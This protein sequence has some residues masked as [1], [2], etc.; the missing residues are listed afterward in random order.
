MRL[1]FDQNLSFRLS[2]RL[3]DLYPGLSQVRLLG[4]DR[5]LAQ[6]LHGVGSF[7]FLDSHL[8]GARSGEAGDSSR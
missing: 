5:A 1:L 8:R 2:E 4:L 3:G 7:R 6:T